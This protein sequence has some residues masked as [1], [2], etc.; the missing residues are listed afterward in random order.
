MAKNRYVDTKFW[1]DAFISELTPSEKLIFLYLL[2]N[3]I[4]N[5]AGIY[6]IT[7]KRIAFDTGLGSQSVSNA[8]ERF[9]RAGKVYYREN[10]VILVNFIKNQKLNSNMKVS[11]LHVFESLSNPLKRFL[12]GDETKTYV[13]LSKALEDMR[14]TGLSYSLNSSKDLSLNKED[15]DLNKVVNVQIP[16]D[17]F[18]ELYD[19]KVDRTKC[20]P[21][22]DRL[23]PEDQASAIK[24]IPKY[25]ESTP[26][27][28]YRKNPETFLN[29]RS[30]ENE[31]IVPSAKKDK[32]SSLQDA[33]SQVKFDEQ[34]E[35]IDE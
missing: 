28:N 32:N 14:N 5:V 10:H 6:E 16:F 17:V 9:E 19:K 1:D 35:I 27:K 22:W 4:T 2:T 20:E 26:D 31:I 11:V 21:K 3:P 30:W 18:W 13:S 8:L 15:K 33:L 12:F 25:V 23:N 7:V 29:K 34:G 24:F